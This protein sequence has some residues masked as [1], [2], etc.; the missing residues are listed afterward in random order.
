MRMRTG[1]GRESVL[2][3]HH[4]V[5]RVHREIL[6]NGSYPNSSSSVFSVSSVVRKSLPDRF[7]RFEA[8]LADVGDGVGHR[9]GVPVEFTRLDVEAMRLTS[10][11][12]D[13]DAG[14]ARGNPHPRTRKRV[15]ARGLARL[16]NEPF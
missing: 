13:G 14:I 15:T 6:I 12:L 8:R 11:P 3:T 16:E 9:T 4:R 10:G 1:Q 7:D 5:H 2:R